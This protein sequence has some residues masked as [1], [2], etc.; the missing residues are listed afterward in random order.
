MANAKEGGGGVCVC[1]KHLAA[2]FTH[3]VI[4]TECTYCFSSGFLN[5]V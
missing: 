4:R 1:Y 2:G 3:S 5:N